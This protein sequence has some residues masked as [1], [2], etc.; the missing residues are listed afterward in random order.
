MIFP[1][2]KCSNRDTEFKLYTNFQRAQVIFSYMFEGYSHRKLDELYLMKDGNKSRGWQSMGILHYLG[3][4]GKHKKIFK[5][6]T[7]NEAINVLQKIEKE[8]S[9]KLIINHLLLLENSDEISIDYV[10]NQ[11]E[12]ELKKSNNDTSEDRKARLA[13]ANKKPLTIKIS[14]I[15]FKRNPDVVSE[16][17]YRADGYCENCKQV[18]PFIKKSDNTPYLEVHHCI[19]LAQG[20]DDTTDNAALCPNCHR[21]IHFG[22]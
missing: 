15:I 5:G 9:N 3:I 12:I 6:F 8:N 20:G 14:S 1:E 10:L 21:K 16:V 11:F 18:A 22:V 19:P 13:K 17:L 7:I 4:L 2:L